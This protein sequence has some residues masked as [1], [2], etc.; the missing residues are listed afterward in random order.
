MHAVICGAGI[1]GLAA[2]ISLQRHGWTITLVEHAPA[3]R[4][5]GYMI[6]F[7]GPGYDAAD[8]LGIL[9]LLEAR[10][11]DVEAVEWVDEHGRTHA[12]LHYEQLS[13]ALDGKLFSLLR[14]DV[15]RV[16][17]EALPAEVD[18]RFSTTVT[19]VDAR[20]DGVGVHLGDERI[21]AD[22]LVGADGIHSGI[23]RLVF[24]PEE[25]YLRP[26]GL[27]TAAWFMK[28]AEVADALSGRFVMMS[29][30][31]RMAGV[32]EVEPG[33]LATFLVFEADGAVPGEPLT[34]VRQ[35]FADLGG[36]VAPMIAADPIDDVYYDLVAQVD[37]DTWH[38]GRVVLIGDAAYAVSLVA[39][40]GASLAL[41]GGV[42]L[43]EALDSAALGKDADAVESALAGFEAA[44]R[45]SIVSKQAAG[46]RTAKW[47]VPT[48]HF[49]IGLRNFAMRI[50]EL[51]GLGKLIS[52]VIGVD[53]K[54]FA[55]PAR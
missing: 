50:A 3:L 7:F 44:V 32:Y 31:G 10:S 21:E 34:S 45:P 8:R 29:V 6:D 42:A 13:S 9:D 23:R 37:M 38:S 27:H 33:V 2:A 53:G 39:G 51:P 19:R 40:Q 28:S 36:F 18:V 30:P 5:G 12:R 49:R 1:A 22:L 48:S 11:H 35:R 14:G 43:G 47:F 46:R 41:A 4:D 24:G 26:L 16:L 52:P 54:G 17:A 25:D 20:A 55:P 15:E